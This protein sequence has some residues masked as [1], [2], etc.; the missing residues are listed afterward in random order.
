MP[1]DRWKRIEELLDALLD[2]PPGE[3]R[4]F[5]ERECPDDPALRSEVREILEAG[6]QPAALLD[7]PVARVSA[8]VSEVSGDTQVPMPERVGPY[9][10]ERVIGEGGMGTVFLAHRD[11]GQFD[12][13]VALKLVRRGLHLDS[14]IVRRF[15]EERQIL[16]ALSHPGIARLLDGGIAEDGLPFFA[17]EYVEG[18]P[19]TTYCDNRS[20]GI[21]ER[22]A[23]FAR[24][25]DALA[26]AHAKQIVHRDIKPS[27]ILVTP[28]GHP[29][30]LDFGIAKL[31]DSD[32]DARGTVVTRRSERLLTPEYASP[33]QIRGE[34]VGI[35]A[36]VYCLG[37]LLY[38]LLTGQRPFRRE[39]R[40]PHELERAVLEED[41]TRPSEAVR[42]EPLRRQ[43]RGDLDA[44]VL[45]AMQK[46][47]E[48]RYGSADEMAADVRRHLA[49]QP[50]TAR[51]ASPVY[52][53]RRWVQRHRVPVRSAAAGAVLT[54]VLATMVARAGSPDP[55]VT[56]AT[57][58]I[59]LDPELELH[60][61]LSPDG[62]MIAFAAERADRFQIFVRAVNGGAPV[63]IT[64]SLPGSH[65][66]PQWSPDG[67][68]IAF[69]AGGSIHVVP[70][71][72][73]APHL[74]IAP[75]KAGSWV[76][77]PAWSPDGRSIAYI[78]NW[79]M[80]VRP[81]DGGAPRLI[82]E[83]PAAH[84]LAW[85]PDGKRI[86]FV[87]GNP[88]FVSGESPWGS[89]TNLGN[90]APSSVWVVAARGGAPVQV[91][92]ARSLN[93]SPVWLPDARGL[94]FVSNREGSRDLYRVALKDSGVP[95]GPPVR[96]TTGLDAHT[97]SVSASGRELAY[98][99]FAY[100]GN[101]WTLDVPEAGPVSAAEARPFTGGTQVIEGMSLSPDGRW[102]A[103]DSDRG[104][105]QDIYKV[106]VE[107]GD[108]LQLTN[109]PEDDFVSSWSG[110]GRE[111]ALHSYQG[112]ARRVRIIAARGGEARDVVQSPRD[113][114]SPGLAPDG[115]SLVFT[116]DA[117]GQL[118][119]YLVSRNG[120]SSWSAARRLTSDG[121][122]AGRWAPD[123]HAIVYCRRDGVWLIS[124]DGGTRRR[125][126]G[127]DETT[128]AAPELAIWSP[129]S[130]TIYYKAFDPAGR[131]SLWSAPAVGGP[132]RLLVRF[133]DPSRPSSR[134]EFTTD[135]K[136]FFFT[137]G[138]RQS[139]IWAMELRK[140]R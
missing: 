93:T 107:G 54:A 105:N 83:R 95:V 29:R 44:I 37:V 130:R 43:L 120:D 86:A 112:V 49:G 121:G 1:P 38:E 57:R 20:L 113:Q 42:R 76:A 65:W 31:L 41:P 131:S 73:G 22:L 125:L 58:R 132:A 110:D 17:M 133:D 72:G 106:P 62:R 97:V 102:L 61:A 14:R 16:A 34:P 116:S 118:E 129:D 70:A 46:E 30:L 48:R 139:D 71:Q 26:H 21:E 84:S 82:S 55:L 18:E 103:F 134:P 109:S 40:T 111:I 63:S 8:V 92:D 47:P 23:L 66:R 104:G 39:E 15:R 28:D 35:A 2:L 90:V 117:S 87:S 80:Y 60:P 59:T 13:R 124:P 10:I 99:I 25:C 51:S 7:R 88:V 85:S 77:D 24:V 122:W 98:T 3:R 136:R 91:T 5:L 64:E 81:A 94:L 126:V 89:S 74:M 53:V 96:L 4:A 50:V 78:E 108:P 101:I 19:I 137:V 45:T 11:D 140:R 69:Q 135:G 79:S 27:N 115:Q 100:T 67:S 123:G 138:A 12:Q 56:G 33:E 6:E 119:L 9:R 52:L 68:R 114:R 128:Q 127:I 32:P 75:S 36:D